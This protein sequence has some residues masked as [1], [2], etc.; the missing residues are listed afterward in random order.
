MAGCDFLP[1]LPGVGIKTAAAL[2][3]KN[4]DFVRVGAGGRAG[5]RLGRRGYRQKTGG[6]T[7]RAGWRRSARGPGS[8]PHGPERRGHS[9]VRTDTSRKPPPP[10]ALPTAPP[11]QAVRALRFNKGTQPPPGYEARF[12]RTLWLFRHQRVFCS[13]SRA[14]THLRPLPPGGLGGADVLVPAA[15]LGGLEGGAEEELG[16]LGPPMVRAARAGGRTRVLETAAVAVGCEHTALTSFM[17]GPHPPAGPPGGGRHCRGC[18][19]GGTLAGVAFTT[20]AAPPWRC[21]PG[22]HRPSPPPLR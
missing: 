12:Q 7:G 1:N 2:L 13:A 9:A 4:R 21:V 20:A 16:F 14:L 10:P 17:H 11:P 8:G 15:L 22:S 5:G 18:G 3:L 19:M 6:R